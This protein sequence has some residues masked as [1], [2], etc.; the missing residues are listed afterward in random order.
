MNLRS[1]VKAHG[2]QPGDRC[3]MIL[4][5]AALMPVIDPQTRMPTSTLRLTTG[6]FRG[7]FQSETPADD[8]LLFDETSADGYTIHWGITPSEILMFGRVTDL[9]VVEKRIVTS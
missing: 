3:A 1:V 8:V 2:I 5:K 9:Q 6:T 7:L 4:E